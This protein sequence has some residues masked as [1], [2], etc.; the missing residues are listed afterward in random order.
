MG[1]IFKNQIS[2]TIDLE[3]YRRK[4]NTCKRCYEETTSII[5]DWLREKKIRAT[6]FVVGQLAEESPYLIKEISLNHDIAFHSFDHTP[7]TDENIHSF[8]T[9]TFESKK[10]IEDLVGK[11]I[12]GFRAPCFSLTPQTQWVTNILS[13]LEFEYSSSTIPT[14]MPKFGFPGIPQTPFKWESGIVEFPM[15]LSN[16]LGREIPSIGGAY[17]RFLPVWLMLKT[18]KK[19]G[20]RWT[21]LHPQDIYLKNNFNVVKGLN[22]FQSVLYHYNRKKTLNSIE[23][24]LKCHKVVNLECY[25]KNINKSSLPEFK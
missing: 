17:L 2:V 13:E 7:L 5:L 18:L 19:K 11:K 25:L 3:D 1:N 12:I 24:I 6:F 8:V 9:K 4:K 10:F 21:Y 20:F 16:V 23:T 15:V 22:F 14:K